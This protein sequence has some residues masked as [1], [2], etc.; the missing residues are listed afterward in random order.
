MTRSL[1]CRAGKRRIVGLIDHHALAE[2]FSSET[3]LL[4]DVRPWGSMSSIVAH[5]YI[6][7]NAPMP[8]GVARILMC[9][10]LSDT[11]NLQVSRSVVE[12]ASLGLDSPSLALAQTRSERHVFRAPRIDPRNRRPSSDLRNRALPS[13]RRPSSDLRINR[14]LPS[15]RQAALAA[16][17][18]TPTCVSDRAGR[19]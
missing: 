5:L 8:Q 6:R 4:I 18:R 10:I 15:A 14:A 7:N 16:P 11:L 9:A 12:P 1:F 13:N 2:S 3:P 17:P 19:V